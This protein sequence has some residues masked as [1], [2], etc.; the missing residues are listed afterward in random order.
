MVLD[1]C[2]DRLGFE[3]SIEIFGTS[4]R[5]ANGIFFVHRMFSHPIFVSFLLLAGMGIAIRQCRKKDNF[6]KELL[7]RGIIILVLQFSVESVGWLF[8][9]LPASPDGEFLYLGI[10]YLIG[11]FYLLGTL[12]SLIPSSKGEYLLIIPAIILSILVYFLVKLV[13]VSVISLFFL[14]QGERSVVASFFPLLPLLPILFVGIA[15]GRLFEKR[16]EKDTTN[17]LCLIGIVMI[18]L[19]IIL[20]YFDIGTLSEWRNWGDIQQFFSLTK[21]PP[22]LVSLLVWCGW[23]FIYLFAISRIVNKVASFKEK[24]NTIKTPR[25]FS[26][27]GSASMFFYLSHLYLVGLMGYFFIIK[28]LYFSFILA[29]IV[30]LIEYILCKRYIL[31]KK[32]HYK[33]LKYF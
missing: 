31:F 18:I 10:L 11:M 22:C 20:R 24:R 16:G 14:H 28:E 15:I 17:K 5:Y 23:A 21:Y 32:K 30:I 1:H 6:R 9:P 12:I 13:P 26:T 25:I 7:I 4:Y 3:Q 19:G 33:Y 8:F 2:F 29:F 27:I